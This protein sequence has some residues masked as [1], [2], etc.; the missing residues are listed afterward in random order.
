MKRNFVLGVLTRWIIRVCLIA[1]MFVDTLAVVSAQTTCFQN[2]ADSSCA[3]VDS[4]YTTSMIEKD[5][6]SLCD[7]QP[8]L[9][10]CRSVTRSYMSSPFPNEAPC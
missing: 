2:P 9:S 3:N 4:I 7:S 6:T 1:M 5:L 10:G 8:W